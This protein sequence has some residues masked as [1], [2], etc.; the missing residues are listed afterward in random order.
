[1]GGKDNYS[2]VY[3][4]VMAVQVVAPKRRTELSFS[5]TVHKCIHFSWLILQDWKPEYLTSDRL[6]WK[7]LAELL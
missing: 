3:T 1:M 6:S 4:N 5:S 2:S 7:I